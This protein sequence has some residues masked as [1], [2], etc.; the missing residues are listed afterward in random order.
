MQGLASKVDP[1]SQW[2]YLLSCMNRLLVD[3]FRFSF[4]FRPRCASFVLGGF[5]YCKR[6]SSVR[7]SGWPAPSGAGASSGPSRHA[8]FPSRVCSDPIHLRY[9][10]NSNGFAGF[11]NDT[12][13]YSRSVIA[14]C[15]IPFRF[16]IEKTNNSWKNG[17]PESFKSHWQNR[18]I[19]QNPCSDH[20]ILKSVLNHYDRN[21]KHWGLGKI[22]KITITLG[23]KK[24]ILLQFRLFQGLRWKRGIWNNRYKYCLYRLK[25]KVFVEGK[26]ERPWSAPVS[27]LDKMV[28]EQCRKASSTFSPVRALVSK[29]TSSKF[30][31]KNLWATAEEGKGGGV[32]VF[33][34]GRIALPFSWAKRDA[35]KNETWRS[36][37][38]SRLLPTSRITTFGL[39]RLRASLS[40][41]PATSHAP[42]ITGWKNVNREKK[43]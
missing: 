40:H 19:I 30:G 27:I 26:S 10:I 31:R 18:H 17:G 22:T 14:E 1:R 43:F 28:L 37:S 42:I 21:N 38:R 29:N 23:C 7:R 3:F 25:I 39:A 24:L 32:F 13:R 4:H 8:E 15:R 34:V 20:W 6:S 16:Q 12:T 41:L 35:S 5:T 9:S 11:V 2:T 33:F 36:A